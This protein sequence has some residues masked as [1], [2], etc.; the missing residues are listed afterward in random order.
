[1][2]A[3]AACQRAHGGQAAGH[4]RYRE[5]FS[6]LYFLPLLFSAAA[7]GI[8]FKALLDPNFGIS[9]AFGLDFLRQDWLGSPNFAFYTVIMVISTAIGPGITGVLID[10]GISFPRQGIGL[11]L[12][13]LA[14]SAAMVPVMLRLRRELA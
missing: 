14:L 7:V 13:C 4:Q 2:L 6:V 11:G 9:R 8:A 1:M 5:V 12:W 3:A 10:A